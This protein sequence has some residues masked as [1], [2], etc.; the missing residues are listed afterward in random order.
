MEKNTES[1][2]GRLNELTTLKDGGTRLLFSE[3]PITI[4]PVSTE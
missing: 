4:L 3:R 2:P 1:S